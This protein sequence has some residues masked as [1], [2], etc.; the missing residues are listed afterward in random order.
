MLDGWIK[1]AQKYVTI[2]WIEGLK[3][4]IMRESGGNPN[5]INRTDSNAQAGHPSQ[6]LMQTIPG[7]FA[8]HRDTRLPNNILD[9]VANIVAGM[10][11][12]HRT[13]G[14]LRNVQQAHAELPAKGYD[15]G[16]MLP[17]GQLGLNVSGKPE[18]VLN[19]AQGEAL[20][21]R[22]AGNGDRHCEH[23][24]YVDGKPIQVIAERVVEKNND[25][26]LRRV[27]AK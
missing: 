21:R 9:P 16:G 4:L 25:K 27:T 11:Y 7:T 24:L 6:G 13:Y 23:H 1:E 14:S 20:E 12:I 3:T 17:S 2:E 15:N 8:A 5:A 22:I 26:I 18:M 19:H 10:N